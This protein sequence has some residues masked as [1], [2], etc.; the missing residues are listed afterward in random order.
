MNTNLVDTFINTTIWDLVWE[1]PKNLN[2][3]DR[4]KLVQAG[5]WMEEAFSLARGIQ[6]TPANN[7]AEIFAREDAKQMVV[8]LIEEFNGVLDQLN[9]QSEIYLKTYKVSDV[10]FDLCGSENFFRVNYLNI[11]ISKIKEVALRVI[12]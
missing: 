6:S 4:D 8:D 9:L 7:P 12:K 3:A 5:E 10:D 1:L 2:K 11:S